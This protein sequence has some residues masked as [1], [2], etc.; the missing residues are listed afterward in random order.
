MVALDEFMRLSEDLT[1]VAPLDRALGEAYLQRCVADLPPHA[2]EVLIRVHADIHAGNPRDLSAEI[3]SRIMDHELLKLVAEQV[4]YLWYVGAFASILG[5]TSPGTLPPTS[6]KY[7]N[8][9][10]YRLALVW[11]LV[12]TQ[13]PMAKRG[14][15]YGEWED[16]PAGVTPTDSADA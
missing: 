2:I 9:E 15:S 16:R 14:L 6:W 11:G 3:E 5:P 1:G 4:I 7:G 8:P 12:H 13:A 10:H